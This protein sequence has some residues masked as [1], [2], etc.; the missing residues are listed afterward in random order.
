[1]AIKHLGNVK[2]RE[3]PALGQI[4]ERELVV[5]TFEPALYTSSNDS[6]IIKLAEPERGGVL[7]NADR[8]YNVGDLVIDSRKPHHAFIA[9]K[10]QDKTD[11]GQQLPISGINEYWQELDAEGYTARTGGDQDGDGTLN[12]L[13]GP[14]HCPWRFTPS[15]FP[16]TTPNTL[17]E[18][19]NTNA[20]GTNPPT[21]TIPTTEEV[22]ATWYISGLGVDANFDP[23]EYTFI[24]GPLSGLK[25][26]D[27]DTMMWVDGLSGGTEV[28]HHI[29]QPRVTGERAGML[30][31]SGENYIEGDI[32]DYKDNLYASKGNTT[33][34]IPPENNPTWRKITG[35]PGYIAGTTYVPGDIVEVNGITYQVPPGANSANVSPPAAPWV[36]VTTEPERGGVHWYSAVH[37]IK[38]DLVT[39]PDGKVYRALDNNSGKTPSNSPSDWKTVGG[40]PKWDASSVYM[41]DD[42]VF[43]FDQIYIAGSNISAGTQPPNGAWILEGNTSFVNATGDSM[44]GPLDMGGNGISNLGGPTA[45][46]DAINL[47]YANGEYINA[48]GDTMTGELILSGDGTHPNA[49]VT[50]SQLDALAADAAGAYVNITG[51]TMTGLLTLSGNAVAL[52]GAVTLQQL[53]GLVASAG[54]AFVEKSG[55]I[56]SGPLEI[57]DTQGPKL[58]LNRDTADGRYVNTSG[59]TMTGNLKMGGK[60]IE[61]IACGGS[62]S[63]A[64]NRNCHATSTLGGTIKIRLSGSNLFITNNGTNP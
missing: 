37:Y 43:V 15:E 35:S 42:T 41:Q 22:G 14:N 9:I 53:T 48:S 45:N 30:W 64:I 52:K 19:P 33:S 57:P 47:G 50:L 46:G 59:D 1:M 32:V 16:P 44:T 18:Y 61:N 27:G 5:N 26:A 24:T 2:D 60:V 13:G 6:D 3:P 40:V 23:I 49:A 56:M 54:G 58:A 10:N 20:G 51:D 31:R 34:S 28:W 39:G 25:V 62:T 12:G 36:E 17:G 7:W 38:G 29:Q 55:D 63:D 8:Y 11:F 4:K 21:T